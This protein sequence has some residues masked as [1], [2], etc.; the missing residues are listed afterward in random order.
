MKFSKKIGRPVWNSFTSER[1]TVNSRERLFHTSIGQTSGPYQ[2]TGRHLFI[3]HHSC[4]S[5]FW[6]RSASS[7]D[8]MVPRTI[9]STIGERS[10]RQQQHPRGMLCLILSL[11]PH[12]CY[13][14]EVDSRQ[15][16]SRVH[17]SNL[18]E[19]VSASLWLTIFVP[20]FTSRW[21]R[22]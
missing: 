3:V 22:F 5:M 2:N 13:S 8:L 4:A 10:L 18:V 16:Y 6:L 14:S 9:R 19:S 12:Q 11:L 15:N 20:R 1:V 21:W 7:S 17:T